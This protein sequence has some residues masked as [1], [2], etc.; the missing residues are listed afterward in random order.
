MVDMGYVHGL[1]KAIKFIQQMLDDSDKE[2]WRHYKRYHEIV[3]DRT[4]SVEAN[5]L[6]EKRHDLLAGDEKLI[7]LKKRINDE[8]ESALSVDA[9]AV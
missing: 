8:I 6:L 4:K 2:W 3:N 7:E 1:E 9:E 5:E